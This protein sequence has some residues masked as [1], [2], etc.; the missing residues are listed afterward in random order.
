MSDYYT[1]TYDI[2]NMPV[3]LDTSAD[4]GPVNITK[5]GS[6]ALD[7]GSAKC[8]EGRRQDLAAYGARGCD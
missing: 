7:F 2:K 8:G 6:P 5:P 3:G 1:V 4:N